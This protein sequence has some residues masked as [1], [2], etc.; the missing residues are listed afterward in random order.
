MPRRRAAP[1]VRSTNIDDPRGT[2]S[3]VV[4]LRPMM[5]AGRSLADV[6][7]RSEQCRAAHAIDEHQ[8]PPWDIEGRGRAAPDAHHVADERLE[9]ATR[10]ATNR[11][12]EHEPSPST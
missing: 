11:D 4:G 10:N 3:A 2:S 12:R 8:R 1:H 7:R 6:L 5:I 9:Y